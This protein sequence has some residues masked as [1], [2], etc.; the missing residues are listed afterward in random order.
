ML[1]LYY[2]S[3]LETLC[4][5]LKEHINPNKFY[6]FILNHFICVFFHYLT[7]TTID[8]MF[9]ISYNKGIKLNN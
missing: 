8:K 9:L 7:R 4:Q 2:Y 3:A 5:V 6:N 1:I